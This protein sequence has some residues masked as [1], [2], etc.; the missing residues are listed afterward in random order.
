MSHKINSYKL[1]LAVRQDR[2]LA[3]TV[4]LLQIFYPS[5]GGLIMLIVSSYYPQCLRNYYT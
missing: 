2:P 4:P 1:E 3:D 5:Y